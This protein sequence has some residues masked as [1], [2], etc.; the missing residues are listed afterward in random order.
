MDGDAAEAVL[1]GFLYPAAGGGKE[2]HTRG[3]KLFP[4]RVLAMLGLG[5]RWRG[6]RI[7]ATPEKQNT[8]NYEN[9]QL[10]MRKCNHN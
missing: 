9:V 10:K 6:W 7:S 1:G 8:K 5:K 3:L 4:P 2:G